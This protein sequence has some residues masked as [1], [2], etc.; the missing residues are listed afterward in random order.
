MPTGALPRRAHLQELV[1]RRPAPAVG[2]VVGV[3]GARRVGPGE[4]AVLLAGGVGLLAEQLPLER[5]GHAHAVLVHGEVVVGVGRRER[6]L[7]EQVVLVADVHEPPAE[8]VEVDLLPGL[9][10][11]DHRGRLGD[12][13]R[14]HAGLGVVAAHAE[15][16]D[17]ERRQL[18]VAVEHAGEGGLEHVAVV[19]ARAHDHLAVH[20]DAVVEQRPEPAQARGA[21]AGCGARRRARRGRWRGSTR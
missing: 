14:P 17:A 2:L 16:H 21:R 5:A 9:D 20:L 7:G 10:A 8:R 1:G 3:G 4:E 12:G 13:V 6:T 19:D 15:R 11:V 18:R